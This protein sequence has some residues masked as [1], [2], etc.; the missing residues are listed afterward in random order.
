MN[1]RQQIALQAIRHN[2]QITEIASNKQVSRDFVY[3]Q[4]NKALLA[5]NNAFQPTNNS[6]VLFYLSVYTTS[7]R[8]IPPV[9]E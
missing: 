6:D 5:I 8:M 9:I 3:T 4:K 7:I 2:E 1:E